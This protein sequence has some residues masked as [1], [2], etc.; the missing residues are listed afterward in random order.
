M[1]AGF[2]S[3]YFAKRKRTA[4]ARK[5]SEEGGPSSSFDTSDIPV[6]DSEAM[7]NDPPHGSK[8]VEEDDL[9]HVITSFGEGAYM[10]LDMSADGEGSNSSKR[11]S[12]SAL[13]KDAL[14]RHQVQATALAS[15]PLRRRFASG[16][17]DGVVRLWDFGDPISL[18]AVRAR[19]FGRVSSLKFSAHGNA[20]VSVYVSGHVAVWQD[21]E[22]SMSVSGSTR[23]EVRGLK[24]IPAF[25]NRNASDVV[26]LDE[27][28]TIAAV[29][30]P[31]SPPAVGHGLRVYDTRE[32][33]A[34]YHTSWSARVHNGGEARCLGLLED[35][36]R[37]VT[38]GVDGT[39]SVV[40]LRMSRSSAAGGGVQARVAELPAH[41][42]EVTCLT[43]ESP[44]GRALIS[45]CRNGDIKMWDSRTLLQL[46][47]LPAAHAQ[48]RHYWSGNGF[49]G[50][51]GSYGATAAVLTDRSLISCGGDGMLKVWG[52]GY[53]TSDLSVL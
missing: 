17:S 45:G 52:P 11:S 35:R 46:D 42:D 19:Q 29:G 14:W 6:V 38:G 28:F 21:P 7:G 43:L 44:R 24:V 9:I 13:G 5:D 36:V 53:S 34:M 1:P 18:G 31:A 27:R 33:N 39:L 47:H 20:L 32:A 22:S 37:V 12:F 48:T 4:D 30:D 23:R 25:Q 40:D 10:A 2:R 51:V 26:F 41:D 16:G 49:G 15:H 3:H 50:M 8:P